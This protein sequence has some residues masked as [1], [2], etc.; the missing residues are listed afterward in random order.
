M[1]ITALIEN[2]TINNDLKPQHGLCLYIETESHKLLVDTGADGLFLENAKKL[3][4]DIA[5]VDTLVITHG[6]FDHGGGLKTFLQVN[7]TAKVYLQDTAFGRHFIRVLKLVK[8]NIGLDAKLKDHPQIVFVKGD[9]RIDDEI[10]LLA[11]PAG[12]KLLS[13]FNSTLWAKAGRQS[14]PD[15]FNHEQSVLI[16][17]GKTVLIGGCAHRGIANIIDDAKAKIQTPINACISGF[18]LFN[19]ATKATE[20]PDKV[21]LLAEELK[22]HDTQFYTCHCTGIKAYEILKA[23]MQDSIDYLATGQTLE[24]K[25]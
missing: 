21:K 17:S 13:K 15:D 1:K 7:K 11:N 8:V 25:A 18:H 19:P 22:K 23:E 24:F 20:N 2:A 3:G 6:H 16:S 14:V 5:A 10:M 4:I 9:Y 12:K